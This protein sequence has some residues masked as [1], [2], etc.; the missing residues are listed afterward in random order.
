MALRFPSGMVTISTQQLR[1][2]PR[3]QPICGICY[4]PWFL[5]S[6]GCIGGQLH[7]LHPCQHLV[8]SRCWDTVPDHLKEECPR[9]KVEVKRDEIVRVESATARYGQPCAVCTRGSQEASKVSQ[10]EEA[11]ADLKMREGLN[12]VDVRAIMYYMNL[13]ARLDMIKDNLGTLLASTNTLTPVHRDRLV[14]FLANSPQSHHDTAHRKVEVA[15]MAFNISRGTN[16]TMNDLRKTLASA[17]DWVKRHFAAI[18]TDASS[19]R[20]LE[21]KLGNVEAKIRHLK[22]RQSRENAQ[23]LEE[24]INLACQEIENKADEKAEKI[25]ARAREKAAKILATAKEES[26]KLHSHGKV[27]RM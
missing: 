6:D 15:L 11:T 9:C 27:M 10:A 25:L 16:F 5:N 21:N 7:V 8:G 12:D 1:Q 18:F 24:N 17:E 4:K 3:T 23:R 2:L 22:D 19:L 13:R 14:L 26:A 20:R